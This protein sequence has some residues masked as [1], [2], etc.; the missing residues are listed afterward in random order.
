MAYRDHPPLC[1]RCG[2]EL[3]RRQRRD[4]WRC[5]GCAGMQFAAAEL[6]RRVRLLAPDISED[7]I[8]DVM[9]ARRSRAVV[10]ARRGGGGVSTCPSCLRPMQPV[11]MGGVHVSRCDFDD[12]I[13]LA[14]ADLDLVIARAG[15]RHQ[16]QRS[17][18]A[19]LFSLLFAS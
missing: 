19:R 14:A 4:I 1:P 3:L 9:T 11:V 18:V 6:E 16:S 8:L 10:T 7:V 13:W 12:Q 5:P 17:W 15:A 2:I